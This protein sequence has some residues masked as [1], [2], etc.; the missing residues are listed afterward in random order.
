MEI[1]EAAA[2][3]NVRSQAILLGPSAVVLDW[4]PFV[5]D[6]LNMGWLLEKGHA[7]AGIVE[8]LPPEFQ[9]Q[10]HTF[11]TDDAPRGGLRDGHN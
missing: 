4:F 5:A 10:P 7:G 3:R 9:R 1:P 6:C 11:C 2:V 8:P